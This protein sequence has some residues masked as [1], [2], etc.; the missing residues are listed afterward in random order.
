MECKKSC[1]DDTGGSAKLVKSSDSDDIS[2]SEEE[3]DGV[4]EAIIGASTSELEKHK[5]LIQYLENHVPT[6]V[7]E[8]EKGIIAKLLFVA[9]TRSS[10]YHHVDL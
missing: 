10:L 7:K 4:S 6:S 3:R 1:S 5:R 8:G 9:S 2:G